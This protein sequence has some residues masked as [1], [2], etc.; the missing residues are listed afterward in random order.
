MTRPDKTSTEGNG[1][2]VYSVKFHG[3]PVL[4]DSGLSLQLE[5]LP[6]LGSNVHIAGSDP[7]HGVDDYHL[8]NQKI[9][10]VHAVYNSVI[11]HLAESGTAARSMDIEARA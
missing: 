11:V 8:E 2:L 10:N 4:E 3:K 6:A 7:G 5:N 9:S 1:R